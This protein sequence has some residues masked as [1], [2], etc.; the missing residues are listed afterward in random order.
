MF[1]AI[2]YN[3]LQGNESSGENKTDQYI[4]IYTTNIVCIPNSDSF[5]KR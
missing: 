1:Q 5:V 3:S 2:K 4:K